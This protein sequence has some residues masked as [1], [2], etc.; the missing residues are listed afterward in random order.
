MTRT[1]ERLTDALAARAAAVTP[2]SV[3]PLPALG[4]GRFRHHL[5]NR[6]WSASLAPLAGAAA[7]A[8]IAVVATLPH[9]HAGPMPPGMP[10]DSALLGVA[11]ASATS[12]W[13]VGLTGAGPRFRPLIMH[14]NG[15]AWTRSTT[16]NPRYGAVL[17]A[18]AP[19]SARDAWAVGGTT[20][21]THAFEPYILRWNGRV[22]RQMPVPRQTNPTSLSAVAVVSASDVWAVGQAAGALI[23]HWNGTRWRQVPNPWQRGNGAFDD[24]LARSADD[25]WVAGKAGSHSLVAHW[26]GA[27]WT[28]LGGPGHSGLGS[29]IASLAV[30]SPRLAW[31]VGSGSAGFPAILRWNGSRWRQT[32]ASRPTFGATLADVAAVSAKQAWA[33]GGRAQTWILRWQG[34]VWQRVPSPKGGREG[35]L[36]GIFAISARD[37]WA[38]GRSNLGPDGRSTGV[39]LHWNGAAWRAAG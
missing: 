17:R 30:V 15:R 6:K 25:V 33:V 11:A 4:A 39:I 34:R 29:D 36:F 13:A 10:R 18:V 37:I 7:I 8:A 27:T 1:E 35:S 16:P 2:G 38:V 24:I 22:W 28:R 9:H 19:V 20:V 32:R 14:W 21:A 5:V 26:N 12:V 31:V 3:R 23:L